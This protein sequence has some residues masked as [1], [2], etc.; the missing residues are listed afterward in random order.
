MSVI[1]D[2]FDFQQLSVAE[3][4][5]LVERIW[6]S[7]ATEESEIPVTPAQKEELDRRL[8]AFRQS[9]NEGSTW[10]EVKAR[11]QAKK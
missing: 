10:E 9:P 5:L 11:L 7:I 3:R 4:I 1:S 8:E 2:P 6:D